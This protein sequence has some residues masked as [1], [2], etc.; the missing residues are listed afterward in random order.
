MIISYLLHKF[1]TICKK[2]CDTLALFVRPWRDFEILREADKQGGAFVPTGLREQRGYSKTCRDWP[3]GQ[4]VRH[5][6]VCANNTALPLHQHTLVP[7]SSQ[8]EDKLVQTLRRR[9][10]VIVG[11]DAL[12][13]PCGTMSFVQT[14]RLLAINRGFRANAVRPY[15]GACGF[16]MCRGYGGSKPPPYGLVRTVRLR[17]PS[18]S[19]GR[20]TVEDG[21]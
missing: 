15:G 14:S 21:G 12:G 4:S 20:G 17:R 19:G 16:G 9:S 18:P 13:V 7:L 5:N 10:Y 2:Y 3:P 11:D 6:A 8:G 1:N